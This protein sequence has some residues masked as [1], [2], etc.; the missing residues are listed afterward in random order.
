MA[1]LI[2]M[3]VSARIDPRSQKNM[4]RDLNNIAKTLK[5][6]TGTSALGGQTSGIQASS[7]A[8]NGLTSNISRLNLSTNTLNTNFTSLRGQLRQT[9]TSTDSVNK[10]FI[11]MVSNIGGI[12]KKFAEWVLVA[13]L[14]Y[15]PFRFLQSGIKTLIEIDK[16]M[17]DIAKVTDLTA[18]E[19]QNLAVA[20]ANVGTEFGRTAQEFLQAAVDFSR[21][22]LVDQVEE[23]SRMSLLLA[24]VGD[25][26]IEDANKT[27]IATV[28]GMNLAYSDTINVIDKMDAVR[29]AAA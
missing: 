15:A 25:M 28:Q 18:K 3:M 16:L 4:Q 29:M 2:Q 20:A 9:R 1:D 19:M 17:I 7:T 5:L 27:I 14:I 12:T 11:G 6:N 23:L 8:I 22:G 21:A 10:G 26:G 13:N 24:N